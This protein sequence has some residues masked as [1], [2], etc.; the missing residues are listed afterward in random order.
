M[1]VCRPRLRGTADIPLRY[2]ARLRLA[3]DTGRPAE[4]PVA[5]IIDPLTSRELEVLRM[6]AAGRSDQA[7]AARRA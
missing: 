2:L 3:F 5:G 4:T 7:I 6:L 1:A